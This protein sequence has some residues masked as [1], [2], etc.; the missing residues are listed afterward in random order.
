[1]NKIPVT[2]VIVTIQSIVSCEKK[3]RQSRDNSTA[4]IK[5]YG[6]SDFS[7]SFHNTG[8]SINA[9]EQ[10]LLPFYK[11][12]GAKKLSHLSDGA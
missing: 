4:F 1:M 2:D 5:V 8:L 3:L 12:Q 9:L 10:N 11:N 7:F 6:T